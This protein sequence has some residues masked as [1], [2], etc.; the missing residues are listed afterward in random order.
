MNKQL[1]FGVV[2]AVLVLAVV[3]FASAW[4]PFGDDGDGEPQLGPSPGVN[5]NECRAD[6]TCEAKSVKTDDL[7]VTSLVGGLYV[8]VG[9]DIDGQLVNK[10]VTMTEETRQK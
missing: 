3:S 7:I 1:F 4:W 9:G 5:A 8:C 2:C 10:S 6:S